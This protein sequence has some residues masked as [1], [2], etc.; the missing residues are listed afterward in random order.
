M[1]NRK[2][3]YAAIL[4]GY[5]TFVIV[6]SFGA[7]YTDILLSTLIITI[8]SYAWVV[9]S[10]SSFGEMLFDYKDLVLNI[11]IYSFIS[12]SI[13]FTTIVFSPYKMD[14]IGLA[15]LLSPVV[16]WAAIWSDFYLYKAKRR[17]V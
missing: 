9:K 17:L 16:I 4:S 6:F 5:Y 12:F 3:A 1:V 7:E 13:A 10:V 8:L 15:V 11:F 14:M 2:M